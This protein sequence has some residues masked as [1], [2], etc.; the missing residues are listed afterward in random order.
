MC[1]TNLNF[2][3]PTHDVF[4]DLSRTPVVCCGSIDRQQDTHN[5]NPNR[6]TDLNPNPNPNDSS[7][8]LAVCGLV[9]AFVFLALEG[10]LL[11]VL[12]IEDGG[13]GDLAV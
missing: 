2:G 13:R 6:N 1:S 7:E 9:F 5:P 3:I 12:D 8:D 4:L 10:P 11:S